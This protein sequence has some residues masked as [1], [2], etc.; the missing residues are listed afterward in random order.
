MRVITPRVLSIPK[1][2]MNADS[3]EIVNGWMIGVNDGTACDVLRD[4]PVGDP[5]VVSRTTEMDTV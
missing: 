4:K 2:Q 5:V 1:M 3:L